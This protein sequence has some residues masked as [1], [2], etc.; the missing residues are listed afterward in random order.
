ML[1]S[2]SNGEPLNVNYDSTWS[3]GQ[4]CYSPAM[5]YFIKKCGRERGYLKEKW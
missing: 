2:S 5:G 4:F 1:F 3:V